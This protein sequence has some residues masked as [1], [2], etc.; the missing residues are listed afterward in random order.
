MLVRGVGLLMFLTIAGS[1]LHA[2][3]GEDSDP[4][5]HTF[6]FSGFWFYSQP[7]G[8][9]HGTGTQ[10][11]LDV[12]RDMQ[13]NSYNTGTLK[14]EWKFTRKNHVFLGLLPVRNTKQAVLS[15]TVVFEGQTFDA[16]LV[17]RSELETYAL[18]PGYQFD[19]IR[20]RRGHLG[21][22]AQ[23][24]LFYIKGRISAAA[25]TLNGTSRSAQASSSTI[26]A[27]LPVAGPDFRYYFI[28][29]SSRF[30]VAGNLLGMYFFGYGNFISSY[31]TVGISLNQHLNFQGGYQLGSRFD[32]NTKND[33]IGLN[34]TQR[35]AVAG[36]EF[37][38]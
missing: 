30:F 20:R 9:F 4:D 10:G 27:P 19:I 34:L 36:L 11:S 21:I 32:I 33:R 26:R 28:P 16:G 31:G 38:F 17:A 14:V 8:S 13:L 18:T 37:S 12:E 24:D 25:Q 7:S 2:A 29:N 22:V 6:R 23:L 5:A 3:Q 1:L 15:R 35:G